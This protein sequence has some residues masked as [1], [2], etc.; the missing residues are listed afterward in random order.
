MDELA[1]SGSD[2]SIDRTGAGLL[3]CAREM[4]HHLIAPAGIEIRPRVDRYTNPAD[5]GPLCQVQTGG[6]GAKCAFDVRT[7]STSLVVLGMYENRGGQAMQKTR[8]LGPIGLRTGELPLLGSGNPRAGGSSCIAEDLPLQ[9][10]IDVSG[11]T[12]GY[13]SSPHKQ[14]CLDIVA[15]CAPSDVGAGDQ[16]GRSIDDN[17]LR[18]QGRPGCG[19]L[20]RRPAQPVD[21]E[22]GQG[23][24]W[25][26]R[27]VVIVAGVLGQD[28]QSRSLPMHYRRHPRHFRWK[29]RYPRVV[30]DEHGTSLI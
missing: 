26:A 24:S 13:V 6:A 11:E 22:T 4:E 15:C 8:L 9:K 27:E 28:G 19:S 3:A 2:E 14:S 1:A 16:R 25:C 23:G 10:L 17:H 30:C 21:Y 7:V 18:V 29:P 12:A 20:V 5:N